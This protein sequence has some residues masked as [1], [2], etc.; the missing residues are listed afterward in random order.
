MRQI[1]ATIVAVSLSL[2]ALPAAAQSVPAD[3][4]QAAARL[5]VRDTLRVWSISPALDR[6]TVTVEGVRGDTL[7]VIPR[8]GYID[9][10]RFAAIHAPNIM[11][12]DLYVPN[13]RPR[14]RGRS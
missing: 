11:R 5:N 9:E 1:R 6:R 13:G 3:F 7:R 10:A 2:S 4:A 14:Q 8:S 12:I